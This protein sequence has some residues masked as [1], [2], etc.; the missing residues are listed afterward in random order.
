MKPHGTAKRPS[1]AE[2]AALELEVAKTRG[3]REKLSFANR[4]APWAEGGTRCTRCAGPLDPCRDGACATCNA[5]TAAEQVLVEVKAR[6][7]RA[8]T[9]R[10]FRRGVLAY[11]AR[12][13]GVAHTDDWFRTYVPKTDSQRTALAAVR[14]YRGT[15][16]GGPWCLVLSG[17]TGTGKTSLIV[18]RWRAA[19]RQCKCHHFFTEAGAYEWWL[20]ARPFVGDDDEET[21]AEVEEFLCN[22][23]ILFLDDLGTTTAGREGWIAVVNRVVEERERHRRPL[24]ATTNLGPADLARLY[25]KRTLS[26]L[27]G[28]LCLRVDGPDHR[29]A[30]SSFMQERAA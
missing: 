26:R 17:P 16:D 29:L 24:V 11:F 18:A 1:G 3:E 2:V 20:G 21:R 27:S 9:L 10:E 8:A 5:A 13:V 15:V 12:W 19:I 22:A 30:S 4:L 25:G 7:E 6:R 23:P 14:A 28:G